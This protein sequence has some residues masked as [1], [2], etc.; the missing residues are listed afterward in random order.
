MNEEEPS[1]RTVAVEMLK[2]RGSGGLAEIM[3]MLL[4]L[5]LLHSLRLACPSY[6]YCAI[7]LRPSRDKG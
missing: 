5:L 4:L 2:K 7:G 1:Y 6:S 3:G